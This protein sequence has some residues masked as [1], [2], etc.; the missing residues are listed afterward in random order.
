MTSPVPVPSLDAIAGDPAQA[1]GLPV[2]ATRALLAR[3]ALAHGA[4]VARLLEAGGD[5]AH[6][7]TS[8]GEDQLLDVAAVAQ[9]LGVSPDSVYRRAARW[10]FT[11]RIGRALRF[12]ARGLDVY[13]RQRAGR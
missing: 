3:C 9:R 1:A 10:P 7:P 6:A 8:G 13:L 11:I 4:L 5:G 2:E 12:S